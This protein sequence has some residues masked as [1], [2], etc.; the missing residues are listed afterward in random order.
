MTTVAV[1]SGMLGVLGFLRLTRRPLLSGV[2]GAWTSLIVSMA[3]ATNQMPQ[4]MLRLTEPT[5]PSVVA[6]EIVC[7]SV[8]EFEPCVDD[9][10]CRTMLSKGI[11]S[12]SLLT[13]VEA[14]RARAAR[15]NEAAQGLG[16]EG[17]SLAEQEPVS[18]AMEPETWRAHQSAPIDDG[19]SADVHSLGGVDGTSADSDGRRQPNSWDAVRTRYAERLAT[20]GRGSERGGPSTAALPHRDAPDQDGISEPAAALEPEVRVP[21]SQHQQPGARSSKTKNQW[22]DDVME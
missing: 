9:L 15:L 8:R 12:A 4:M 7:P 18:R 5:H 6:D 11:K 3:D 14:C 17:G 19:D 10:R 13:C 21:P 2:A 16:D 1:G 20:G 22:G